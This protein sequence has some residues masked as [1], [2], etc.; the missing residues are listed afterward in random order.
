[1]K[2][3][4]FLYFIYSRIKILYILSTF[5]ISMQDLRNIQVYQSEIKLVIKGTGYSLFLNNTFNSHPSEVIINDETID[6]PENNMYDFNQDINYITL[7]YNNHI[8]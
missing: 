5:F 2:I 3:H 6:P 7:I 1:M 4:L 8:Q